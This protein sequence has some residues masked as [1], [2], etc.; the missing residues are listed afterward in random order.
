[1]VGMGRVNRIEFATTF[2]MGVPLDQSKANDEVL[3]IQL[4]KVMPTNPF[5]KEA[6]SMTERLMD[7]QDA[8]ANCDFQRHTPRNHSK[9]R[10]QCIASVRSVRGLHI[11]NS[12]STEHGKLSDSSLRSDW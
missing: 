12:M 8:T 10:R 3:N 1:M 7:V 5:R 2:D 6:E 9:Q 4:P 11:Q